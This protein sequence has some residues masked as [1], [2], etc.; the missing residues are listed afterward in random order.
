MLHKREGLIEKN[1]IKTTHTKN[2]RRRN[3]R[4]FS[5][6]SFWQKEQSRVEKLGEIERHSKQSTAFESLTE[7]REI[8]RLPGHTC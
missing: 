7:T 1:K 4:I 2:K 6:E 8:Y 5:H 3:E